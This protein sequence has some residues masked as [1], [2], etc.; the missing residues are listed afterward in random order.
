MFKLLT[1]YLDR[2]TLANAQK[3]RAYERSHPMAVC[4]LTPA[5]QDHVANAIHHANS[6]KLNPAAE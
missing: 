6:G 2:P 5:E 4:M 3:V 1:K